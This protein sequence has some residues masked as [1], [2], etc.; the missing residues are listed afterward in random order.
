[1]L[2]RADRK[3]QGI[4]EGERVYSSAPKF[5]AESRRVI[6]IVIGQR[7]VSEFCCS[8]SPKRETYKHL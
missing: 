1:M 4:R 5:T 7:A 3:E 8:E 6:I 2:N